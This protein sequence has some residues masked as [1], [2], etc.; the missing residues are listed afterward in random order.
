ML[1]RRQKMTSMITIGRKI[2]KT[3]GVISGESSEA[4]MER[5]T[6]GRSA[7]KK[8][9]QPELSWRPM[10]S[11]QQS[12]QLQ[13]HSRWTVKHEVLHRCVFVMWVLILLTA[14]V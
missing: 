14:R 13:E 9:A 1:K 3:I 5:S 2:L 4:T 12:S 6:N 8:Q 10:Q 11:V 7:M